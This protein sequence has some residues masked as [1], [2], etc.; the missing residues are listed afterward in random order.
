MQMSKFVKIHKVEKISQNGKI[1]KPSFE[2]LFKKVLSKHGVKMMSLEFFYE[3]LEQLSEMVRPG[4]L[5]K[6][7]YIINAILEDL[8]SL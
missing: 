2:I 7:E 6:M 4:D 3:A 1:I 5:D 8:K